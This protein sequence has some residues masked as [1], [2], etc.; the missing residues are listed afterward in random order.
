LTIKEVIGWVGIAILSSAV[1]WIL[2]TVGRRALRDQQYLNWAVAKK[3]YADML[4]FH[5][6]PE[7][8]YRHV[9]GIVVSS[10]AW[11]ALIGVVIAVSVIICFTPGIQNVQS[12]IISGA[13]LL[14]F[15]IC[16]NVLL[17]CK[18][19]RKVARQLDNF[20]AYRS[21]VPS[22]IVREVDGDPKFKE[23]S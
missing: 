5:Q 19:L 10:V 14:I 17:N 15:L 9:L 6:K 23:S 16:Y 8:F 20:E 21:K 18:G 22:D 4:W 1:I 12:T 11:I 2:K 7:R 13:A 3:Q